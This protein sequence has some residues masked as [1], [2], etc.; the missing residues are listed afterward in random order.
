MTLKKNEQLDN[1]IEQLASEEFLIFML[2]KWIIS[3]GEHQGERYSIKDRPYMLGIIQDNF[4]FIDVMKSAQCGISEIEVAR[5][6]FIVINARR[7]VLYTFPAGEQMQQF[8]DA[9]VRTSIVNNEYLSKYVTGSLNLKKFSLN[10]N[11]LYFRGVQ[12]RRQVISVDVSAHFGDEIDEY[13]DGTINTLSKRMGA[14]KNPYRAYFSTPSYHGVGAALYFYG[15][16][17][18]KER[19]SDQ[20]FWSLKCEHC[21]KWNEDLSWETN[22]RDL[23]ASDNK[24]TY[25]QPNVIIICRHCGK[26][27]N[28][29]A[30]GCWVPQITEN[31]NYCHGYH[32]SKLFSPTGD[33]NQMML[34][35]K[36]PI[37]EQEFYNSD[38][39]LPYEPIGSKLT[40]A[41]IDSCR[42]NYQIYFKSELRNTF[43]GVDIGNKIHGTVYNYDDS[44][45]I[46]LLTALEMD[47]WTDMPLFQKDFHIS[48]MVI[49]A[50]PD[51]DE[52]IAFQRMMSNI[53]EVWLAYFSQAM[54]NSSDNFS[55]DWD[56]NIV[57]VHRTLMMMLVSDMIMKKDLLLPIDI[58]R[59]R[60]FYE[61][62]KSPIK[63][64]K[65]NMAGNW[66]PF[67]PKT[68]IPDHFYFSVLYG[69]VASQCKSKP[70][71][72]RVLNTG[73]Y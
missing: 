68:R 31:T 63:A 50:N 19:G 35:S 8:V 32:V 15:N 41:N 29:L 72:F 61:H 9:R 57:K 33:L 55:L 59:V 13:E 2:E 10:H 26:G 56:T 34:D 6:I 21:G 48:S 5:A 70:G 16:E 42:G 1:H 28:R 37:K 43:A 22:V 53:C 4:P 25:Y 20:R 73:V 65:Q 24:S 62:L 49:D 66:I 47:D 44:G 67:Y 69:L 58:R 64:L 39:G 23:N 46:K 11:Q 60:D 18:Q 38:L 36:D 71:V 27:I 17:S 7:N 54:E 30:N 14:S 51:K 52:A 40:D 3:S 12:K 45:R